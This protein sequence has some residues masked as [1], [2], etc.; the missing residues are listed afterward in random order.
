MTGKTI[1][2]EV[3][4]SD[5]IEDVKAGIQDKEGI[6]SVLQRLIFNGKQLEDGRTLLTLHLAL[7]LRGGMQ[8]FVKTLTGDWDDIFVVGIIKEVLIMEDEKNK[9][10]EKTVGVGVLDRLKNVLDGCVE[11]S[12]EE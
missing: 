11:D 7:R 6:P 2:L 5:A 3:E 12:Y 4:S 8:I 1:T 10:L 9:D